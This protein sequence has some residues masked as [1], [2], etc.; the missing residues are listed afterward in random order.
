MK[1]LLG[2]KNFNLSKKKLDFEIVLVFDL[3]IVQCMV[4][5]YNN[6]KI[7]NQKRFKVLLEVETGLDA[8]TL[9]LVRCKSF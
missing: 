9:L 3:L 8:A 2:K 6:N 4:E 5:D 7:F 1:S